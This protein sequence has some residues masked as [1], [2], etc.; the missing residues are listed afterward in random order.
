[1]NF[2]SQELEKQYNM[3]IRLYPDY[4]EYKHPLINISD[5]FRAYYAL[6]D[7]FTDPSSEKTETM[8]LGIRSIDLLFSALSRQTVS[9]NGKA[10]YKEPLDIC[11]T[12]F[13][14]MVKNHSFSDGNKRTAL[15]ILIYQ[16]NLYN[17]LPNVPVKEFEKMVVAVAANELPIKYRYIWKKYYKH[18]D[19]EVKT[20]SHFLRKSTKKKDNSYHMDITMRDMVSALQNCGVECTPDGVKI[21]FKRDM[22]K[23]LFKPKESKQYTASFKGWTRT[24]GASTARDILTNLNLYDQFPDYQSFIDG[25]S[26]FYNLIEKFEEPLRRLKDE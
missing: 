15:L 20:I 21:H 16:L 10:K 22:P 5:T 19:P 14:G 23:K 9:F 13:Y 8:L 1:M 12:L 3:Y 25:N 26:A 24:V 6:A 7:Y 4:S 11:S 18:E 17:Y 2:Y